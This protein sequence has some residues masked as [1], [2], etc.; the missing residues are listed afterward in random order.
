MCIMM[1]IVIQVFIRVMACGKTLLWCVVVQMSTVN[2]LRPEYKAK[3]LSLA[4]N[5]TDGLLIKIK[6]RVM[7][8]SLAPAATSPS[9]SV[10]FFHC[11]GSAIGL[12]T[13]KTSTLDLTDRQ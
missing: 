8:S 2:R 6:S 7:N 4:P 10:L 12:P 11:L 1:V 13:T 9:V 5:I 3:L